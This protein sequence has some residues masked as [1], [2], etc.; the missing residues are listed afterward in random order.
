MLPDVYPGAQGVHVAEPA[1][2]NVPALQVTHAEAE[3]LPVF[4][5]ALPAEHPVMPPA[6]PTAPPPV[7]KLPAV[8][9]AGTFGQLPSM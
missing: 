7:Q 3:V 5:F 1:S 9:F 8:Q 4:G 6:V 2:A